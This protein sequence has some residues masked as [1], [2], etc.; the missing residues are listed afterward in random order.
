MQQSLWGAIETKNATAGSLEGPENWIANGVS[1]DSRTIETGDLFVALQG[2]NRDAHDYI[3]AAFERGAIAA[4]V[5]SVVSKLDT[6]RSYLRVADTFSALNDLAVAARARNKAKRIAVTGSVGKTGTKEMLKLV[7]SA[8]A[9]VHASAS[10]YNN[11]WGVPLTL[12]RMPCDTDFGIFE[13]GMNHAGE[14]SPLTQ[15]VS[16]HVAIITTVE[17]VHLEFFESVEDIADAKAEIFEGLVPPGVAVLN[18]ESPHIQRLSER[19]RNCGVGNVLVFGQSARADVR[20]IDVKPT[21]DG[22]IIDA[23][24]CGKT[25]SYE[26]SVV[27]LHWV[28]NSL[29][30]LAAAH[31]AGA[32][33][34]QAA[35]SLTEMHAP[36]GRGQIHYVE[37]DGGSI[38][39]VDE[40][41]NANPASMRAAIDALRHRKANS[42]GRR[43]VVLGDMLELGEQ[44]P[45][46]HAALNKH[47]EDAEVDLAFLSGP[48]M[49]NLWTTLDAAIRGY[50][51]A[52]SAE[53]IDSI[54]SNIRAGDTVMVK[55]SLG[56]KMS[57]IVEALLAQDRSRQYPDDDA[58][59]G[60]LS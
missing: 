57:L 4:V 34:A 11:L 48:L 55:G 49:N 30:V 19:A 8:Q 13:I 6:S 29:A 59:A 18:G 42:G 44:G 7:L 21:A 45:E 16:P 24:V 35:N 50:Y 32:D 5:S 9:K 3:P 47:I 39:V 40:S 17:P 58:K 10:S 20:L 26:L 43:I 52:N 60:G 53:L 28:M 27:G 12:A 51:A 22:N 14:I 15:L 41:Y 33:V 38:H 37:I 54:L 31:A 46:L 1:I 2:P 36:K 25:I 23:D 56:S